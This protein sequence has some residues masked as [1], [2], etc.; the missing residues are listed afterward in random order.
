[1]TLTHHKCVLGCTTFASNILNLTSNPKVGVPKLGYMYPYASRGTFEVSNRRKNMFTCY[2]FRNIYTYI[3]EYYFQNH[4][5]LIGKHILVIFNSHF[6]KRNFR[7][8]CS[9]I[10]MLK[11]YMARDSFITPGLNPVPSPRGSF[12]GLSSLNNAPSPRNWNVKHY[13]SVE[14]LSIFRMSSHPAQTQ[15]PSIENFVPTVLPQP[16]RQTVNKSVC[17]FDWFITWFNDLR[18]NKLNRTLTER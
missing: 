15:S 11:G 9:S 14:F 6:V 17:C 18:G 10:E 1:M 4:Y 12:G 3:S 13:K 5:M 8:T 16:R 7:Y 2:Y